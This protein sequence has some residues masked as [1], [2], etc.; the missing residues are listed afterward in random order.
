MIGFTFCGK[1]S[2]R[3]FGIVMKTKNRSMLS[4]RRRR[5]EEIA[6]MHG[7]HMYEGE[8]YNIKLYELSCFIEASSA[9]DLRRKERKVAAWLTQTGKLSFD[10]EPGV[11]CTAK[12]YSSIGP[13][14]YLHA[15]VFP[16][17]FECDPIARGE[18]HVVRTH[19]HQSGER[20]S[21]PYEGE[22]PAP[23]RIILR[24][25]GSVDISGLTI[26]MTGREANA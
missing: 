14:E 25:A 9:E 11:S 26:T 17:I 6:G 7:V 21:V 2:Y 1:H 19:F 20:L 5:Q 4:D 10:D 18:K 3:D 22:A 24:N 16:L 13:E 15:G 8:T 12:I 23:C